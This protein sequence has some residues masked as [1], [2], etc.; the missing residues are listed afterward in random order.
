MQNQLALAGALT[1]A[2]KE[3]LQIDQQL[4]RRGR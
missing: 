4:M 3:R 2:D 1:N